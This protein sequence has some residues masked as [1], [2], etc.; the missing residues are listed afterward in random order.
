MTVTDVVAP[1][2]G[3]AG[4]WTLLGTV[5]WFGYRQVRTG[6]FVPRSTVDLLLGQADKIIAAHEKTIA[7][8]ERQ[9]TSLNAQ[10]EVAVHTYASLR[11][12]AGV[13]VKSDGPPPP[14]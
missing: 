1:L 2:I 9:I 4:P 11:E 6:Q 13:E 5:I 10:T 7:S 3:T 8:Q 14:A 12:A